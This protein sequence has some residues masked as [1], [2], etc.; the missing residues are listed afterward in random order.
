MRSNGSGLTKCST[1]MTAKSAARPVVL[2]LPWFMEWTVADVVTDQ[3]FGARRWRLVRLVWRLLWV[4]GGSARPSSC[5]EQ[6]HSGQ[7]Q[8][9]IVA[10][11]S[12]V[13]NPT[14]SY[15]DRAEML[16]AFT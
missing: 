9:R 10:N 3:Y 4:P 15:A 7:P 13:R 1:P 16:K 6:P 5:L 11:V 12:I 8:N 2:L 14:R